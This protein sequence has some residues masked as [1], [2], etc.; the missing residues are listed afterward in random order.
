[1]LVF[2]VGPRILIR[3]WLIR[4]KDKLKMVLTKVMRM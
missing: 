3:A 2:G 1:M 4:T